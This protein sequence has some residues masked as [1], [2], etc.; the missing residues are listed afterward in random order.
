MSAANKQIRLC[1]EIPRAQRADAR[2]DVESH[3]TERNGFGSCTCA[4][5]AII[6]LMMA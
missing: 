1:R 3:D 6:L 5:S 2:H 4:T